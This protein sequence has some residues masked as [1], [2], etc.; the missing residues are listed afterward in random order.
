VTTSPLPAE[1]LVHTLNRGKQ[2]LSCYLMLAGLW[3]EV[4]AAAKRKDAER[5]D[6]LHDA[7]WTLHETL[8][9][10]PA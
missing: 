10:E 3:D 4:D 1:E 7:I 6:T 8:I 5:L 2:H 9:G